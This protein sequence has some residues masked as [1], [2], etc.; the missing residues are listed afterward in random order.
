MLSQCS[1]PLH[2]CARTYECTRTHVCTLYVHD[3][4]M[5]T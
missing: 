3:V 2:I 5:L 1:E 4:H